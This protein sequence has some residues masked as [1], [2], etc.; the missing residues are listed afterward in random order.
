MDNRQINEERRAWSVERKAKNNAETLYPLRI[1]HY[2]LRITHYVSRFWLSD[3]LVVVLSF[4]SI[5][6]ISQIA[7]GQQPIPSLAELESRLA[8]NP[9]DADAHYELGLT[10]AMKGDVDSALTHLERATHLVPKELKYGNAYRM[11]CIKFRQIDRG[12]KFL[13]KSVEE[14]EK[15]NQDIPELRLNLAL[16]YVDKMPSSDIG[17]VTQARLSTKSIRQLE[18]VLAKQPDSWAGTYALGMNHLYWPKA[19]RHAP[20]SIEAFQRCL[21]IQEKVIKETGEP[22]P[23]FV[24]GYLGLGD[25]YVKDKKFDEA[26][27]V[28]RSAEAHFPDDPHLK[29]RLALT[30]DKTLGK[31]VDKERGLGVVVDTDLTILWGHE[32]VYQDVF[33]NR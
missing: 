7:V 20:K 25:A 3:F 19:L 27:G 2:A 29:Q 22:K 15:A 12:I 24:R 17:I 10:L 31:F 32:S 26:R 21:A 4:L 30:D 23:H 14:M 6:V 1:T 28:W 13:E 11:M 9:N 18:D 16:A 5:A 8:K 33:E